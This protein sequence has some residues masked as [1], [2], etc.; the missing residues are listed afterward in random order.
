MDICTASGCAGSTS[1]DRQS[2]AYDCAQLGQLAHTADTLPDSPDSG[3]VCQR[4]DRRRRRMT[5]SLRRSLV[6]C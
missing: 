6:V 5:L 1:Q 4:F 3:L 2:A